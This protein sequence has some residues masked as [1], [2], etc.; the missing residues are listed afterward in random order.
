MPYSNEERAD[1]V[2]ALP[3]QAAIEGRQLSCFKAGIQV[4]IQAQ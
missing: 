2:L 3:H 4:P 1:M